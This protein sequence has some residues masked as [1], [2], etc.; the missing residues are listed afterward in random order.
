MTSHF[1]YILVLA[2]MLSGTSQAQCPTADF[3]VQTSVCINENLNLE[4]NSTDAVNFEWDFC[5]GTAENLTLVESI[6]TIN[7]LNKSFDLAT[8]ND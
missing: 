3:S 2:L 1:Y 7:E 8:V 5:S 4:N 6:A